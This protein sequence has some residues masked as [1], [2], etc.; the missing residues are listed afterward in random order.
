M[1]SVPP[2]LFDHIPFQVF[3]NFLVGRLGFRFP[4][5]M[6]RGD[7][8]RS[9]FFFSGRD[10]E[11]RP[12]VDHGNTGHLFGFA[13]LHGNQRRVERTRPQHFPEEHSRQLLVGGIPVLSRDE[14]ASVHFW[15]RPARHGP[16]RGRCE[17]IFCRNR[18][19]QL[20]SLNELCV[21]NRAL[22]F[23]IRDL[24]LGSDK[25]GRGNAPIPGR[26]IE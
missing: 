1:G 23:R 4:L 11:E 7:G 9:G 26:Q 14:F 21:L 18:L 22:C 16:L 25:A 10:A 3:E 6:D 20:A 2:L 12:V 13:R 19:C 8:P 5:G 24:A 15:L 17:R